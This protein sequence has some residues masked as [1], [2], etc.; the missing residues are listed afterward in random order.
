MTEWIDRFMFR[1][2]F[3]NYQYYRRDLECG[4]GRALYRALYYTL[5]RKESRKWSSQ[6]QR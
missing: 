5:L 2:H 6:E 1:A 4:P 3:Y